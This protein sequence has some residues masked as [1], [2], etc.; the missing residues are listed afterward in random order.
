MQQFGVT[1]ETTAACCLATDGVKDDS[2]VL[3]IALHT[4]DDT[5]VSV[6]VAG[7]DVMATQRY[8]GIPKQVYDD[9]AI[10][11]EI[12]ADTL[13]RHLEEQGISNLVCHQAH[14]FV[15][16][17]LQESKLIR[18]NISF[19]DIALI[20]KALRFW[21]G[22]LQDANNLI[23]LQA[24][25]ERMRGKNLIGL[26][27]LLPFYPVEGKSPPSPYIPPNKAHEV[28]EI[29]RHQLDTELPF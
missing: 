24:K 4:F 12:V 16:P 2:N 1:T 6:F 11:K 17:K 28:M 18:N 22:N 27:D 10:D 20:H 21:T 3:M 23:D 8:H 14:R 13:Q 5:E 9:L 19:I 26:K 29:F 7:G 25:I 15:R